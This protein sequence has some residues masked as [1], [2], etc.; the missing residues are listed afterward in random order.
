M[1]AHAEEFAPK[2]ERLRAILASNSEAR[3]RGTGMITA[4]K[5]FLSDAPHPVTRI[6][7]EGRLKKDPERIASHA[8]LQDMEKIAAL[9]AAWVVDPKPEHAAQARTFV[10]AWA[11]EC[12]STGDAINDTKLEPLLWAC[13]WL[14]PGFSP[15]EQKVVN[16]WLRSMLDTELTAHALPPTRYN[17]SFSHRLKTIGL[18][19]LLLKDEARITQVAQ[20]FEAQIAADLNA[21]GTSFDLHERDALHYHCYTLEPL[22]TLAL[23]FRPHGR[24]FYHHNSPGGASLE[25]AVRYLIP[26]CDGSRQHEE[27]VNSKNAFDRKR[28]E[29]GESAFTPGHTFQPTQGLRTLELAS[30]FDPTLIPLV[31]QLAGHPGAAFPTWQTVLNA[32]SAP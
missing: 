17:N 27:Y 8:S 15:E 26:F 2:P 18:C 23:A 28:G 4:A 5:G 21:D 25:K 10:L 12:K 9:T 1:T 29:A 30:A 31:A 13:D 7:S 16:T 20:L 11:R 3:Q 19:A 32:A 6:V 22:L 14:A 24:D